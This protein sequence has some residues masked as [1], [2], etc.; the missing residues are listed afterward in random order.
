MTDTKGDIY[1]A[2]QPE[3]PKRI[4]GMKFLEALRDAGIISEGD[5]ISRVVIDAGV[6][7]AVKVYVERYGDDRLLQVATSLEGI[8]I[9]TV[10]K[11]GMR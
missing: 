5:Y 11:D 7:D 8:E 6:R 9:S 1:V 3:R 10:P 2:G 4:L